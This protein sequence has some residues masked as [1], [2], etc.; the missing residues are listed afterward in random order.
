MKPFIEMWTHNLILIS[1]ILKFFWSS[2]TIAEGESV[3]RGMA[4]NDVTHWEDHSIFKA[5]FYFN[6]YILNKLESIV[7][8]IITQKELKNSFRNLWGTPSLEWKAKLWIVK[9]TDF[10]FDAGHFIWLREWKANLYF[11]KV[12][13]NLK[14][15]CWL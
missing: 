14:Y 12:I 1:E 15:N 8:E 5:Q 9:K 11:S 4:R 2:R 10:V 3:E 13:C 6:T 7:H